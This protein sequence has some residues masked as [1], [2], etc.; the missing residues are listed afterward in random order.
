MKINLNKLAETIGSAI[1][2]DSK[3]IEISGIAPIETAKKD[4]VTF[5]SNKK[6]LKYLENTKAAAVITSEEFSVPKGI[7]P[8]FVE[9]PYESFVKVL[10]IFN[11]RIPE[12]VASGISSLCFV[13]DSAKLGKNV[14]VAPFAFIGKNVTI[15]DN[16]IIGPGTAILNDSKI[17]DNCLI[18][19]NVSIMDNSILGNRIILHSGVVI[20]ADG[21][22]FYP[23]KNGLE[24]IPQIGQVIIEDDVEIGSNTCID[25]AVMGA[26][27]IKKGTKL[28]NL[29]QIGHNVSVGSHTVI[30]SMAGV[31][32]STVIGN[33][34]KVGGQAGFSGH[35]RIGNGALI[36]GQAGV[37]KDVP[38]GI[39]VSGYPAKEH[40]KAIKEEIHIRNLPSLKKRV[41][42]QEKKIEALEK[43]IKRQ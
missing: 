35:I 32:G 9:N 4:Q 2:K 39:M 42:D 10:H 29:V 13:D 36:A 27:R 34:V 41:K 14:S 28:D 15:G 18:Y 7:I 25:R 17:G 30:A 3:K 12:D 21:F 1:P 19:P 43:L 40:M 20:G 22:G 37:T 11:T 24:K 16:S 5:L 23:G 33:G 38:G 6:Y 31:S 26:T 8:L